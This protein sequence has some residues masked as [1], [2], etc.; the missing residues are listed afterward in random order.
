MADREQ[1]KVLYKGGA[2]ALTAYLALSAD[3]A[4]CGICQDTRAEHEEALRE[5][6]PAAAAMGGGGGGGGG[7]GVVAVVPPSEDVAVI[8]ALFV[9][10]LCETH[11]SHLYHRT[12]LKKWLKRPDHNTCPMCQEVVVVAGAPPDPL[13]ASQVSSLEAPTPPAPLPPPPLRAVEMAILD[14]CIADGFVVWL[15]PPPAGLVL[16]DWENAERG[17]GF[18]VETAATNL[19]DALRCNSSLDAC[20]VQRHQEPN[21]AEIRRLYRRC[22]RDGYACLGVNKKHFS[23]S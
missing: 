4:C 17:Y 10:P 16:A 20:H 9:V 21:P 22:R 7:G 19:R 5:E 1:R 13:P 11:V 3:E 2:V 14:A 23:K 15:N 8:K 12:C 18:L 6:P